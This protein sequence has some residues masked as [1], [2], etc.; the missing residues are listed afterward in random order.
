M[1]IL[2][3]A[4]R[5]Q[6]ACSHKLRRICWLFLAIAEACREIAGG[7]TAEGGAIE[8]C[9]QGIIA[10]PPG[11][12]ARPFEIIFEAPGGSSMTQQVEAISCALCSVLAKYCGF[13]AQC[14]NL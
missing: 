8:G 9:F 4:S 7:F 14:I 10:P 13:I 3:H 1:I 12:R 5:D 11:Q 6:P 2:T